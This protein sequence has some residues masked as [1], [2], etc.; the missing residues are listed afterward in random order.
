METQLEMIDFEE[1]NYLLEWKYT[2]V[3]QISALHKEN[4]FWK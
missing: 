4:M 2:N 3:M 1:I